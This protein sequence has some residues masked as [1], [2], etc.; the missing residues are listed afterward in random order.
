[1][2]RVFVIS[3]AVLFFTSLASANIV[4]YSASLPMEFTDFTDTMSVAQ[5]DASLGTLEQVKLTLT[6]QLYGAG[7]YENTNSTPYTNTHGRARWWLDQGLVEIQQ[8]TA[9]TLL[10]LSSSAD[11]GYVYVA[12]LPAYD[13]ITDFAGPSGRTV[14]LADL[15]KEEIY[16]YTSPADLA[17]FTGSGQ[18]AFD[19]NGTA[20]VTISTSG[21]SGFTVG[22]ESLGGASVEVEYTYNIPEPAT[23]GL[24]ALGGLL[25]RKKR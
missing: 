25:I 6:G 4:T 19:V 2:R 22:S 23:M 7:L 12:P 21:M 20:Y 1:M 24:L 10:S 18:V 17:A 9:G 15:N 11:S 3:V 8:S 16:T 5:F 13:G 14:V